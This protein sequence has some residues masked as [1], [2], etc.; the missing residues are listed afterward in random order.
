MQALDPVRRGQLS[1]LLQERRKTLGWNRS[2]L[3]ER[4]EKALFDRAESDKVASIEER[5][6]WQ[7]VEINIHHV[8]ILENCPAAPLSN[9]ER[10]ARLLGVC[11]ALGLDMGRV[12][13]LAGG[14]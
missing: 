10:A 11:L 7:S 8:K 5:K 3:C 14:L 1:R 6:L 13:R 12:N 9:R 4:A 2:E